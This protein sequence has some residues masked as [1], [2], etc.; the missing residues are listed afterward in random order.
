MEMQRGAAVED[1]VRRGQDKETH[2]KD[3]RS[4]ALWLRVE[5][6]KKKDYDA[7]AGKL[8]AL[9]QSVFGIPLEGQ[10]SQEASVQKREVVPLLIQAS[11]Y[12]Y[13]PNSYA[14]EMV[15]LMSNYRT[16][17]DRFSFLDAVIRVRRNQH[18]ARNFK[19]PAR[20]LPEPLAR[21]REIDDIVIQ[22]QDGSEMMVPPCP[23]PA[24]PPAQRA[25]VR[26][27]AAGTLRRTG[28]RG[29]R[30]GRV[31]GRVEEV[32]HAPRGS[33]LRG[34]QRVRGRRRP[35][36]AQ[37][38]PRRRVHPPAAH[39]HGRAVQ[40]RGALACCARPSDGPRLDRPAQPLPCARKHGEG[41]RRGSPA[42]GPCADAARHQH[43]FRGDQAGAVRAADVR[44]APPRPAPTARRAPRLTL[45]TRP[46]SRS[47]GCRRTTLCARVRARCRATAWGWGVGTARPP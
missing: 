4:V 32:G 46:G 42:P 24:P 40:G 19:F 33:A 26:P 3:C 31:S 16:E 23:P 29:V 7:F 18:N 21:Q 37:G 12:S 14:S 38:Q 5:L 44:A 17:H 13:E 34:V 10:A 39:V 25:D 43:R 30:D 47:A 1:Q 28:A 36:A 15:R 27:A 20:F 11:S 35:L 45:F 22:S 9:I 41:R 2:F 8:P 6:V